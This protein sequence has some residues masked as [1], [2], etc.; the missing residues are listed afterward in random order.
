MARFCKFCGTKLEDGLVCSCPESVEERGRAEIRMERENEDNAAAEAEGQGAMAS[1][2][3]TQ[4]SVPTPTE[5]PISTPIPT[6]IPMPN[7]APVHNAVPPN[8]APMPAQPKRAS[9]FQVAWKN[10]FPF[11]SRFF[12]TPVQGVSLITNNKDVPLAGILA[13]MFGIV[14]VLFMVIFLA[15]GKG[16]L[17]FF[18]GGGLAGFEFKVNYFIVVLAGIISAAVFLLLAMLLLFVMAKVAK[19]DVNMKAVFVAGAVSFIYPSVFL[20]L[21]CLFAFV[22]FKL[23]IA[24]AALAVISF[25]VIVYLTIRHVYKINED[26][27]AVPV[28]IAMLFLVLLLGSMTVTRASLWAL[29]SAEVSADVN[30]EDDFNSLFE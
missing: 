3:T 2:A 25:I 6:P 4:E 19:A 12:K 20:L 8:P 18:W 21:G 24:M 29:R 5:T 26:S 22:S 11:L 30:F 7:P 14:M 27:T 1:L 13:G 23:M 9:V 15:K 16:L 28:L 17:L 10:V